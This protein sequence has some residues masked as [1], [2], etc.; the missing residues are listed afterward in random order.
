[1][2]TS[3]R[4]R[5]IAIL[6][7]VAAISVMLSGLSFFLPEPWIDSILEWC[8]VGQM[9]HEALMRYVVRGAGYLQ[10]AGG[11]FIWA[12]A[13]DVVRY[14]PIVITVLALLLIGAPAFYLIDATAGLPRWWC[15]MDFGCCFLA[16]GVPLAFCLWPSSHEPVA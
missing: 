5:W 7:R 1:M 3:T 12:I 2:S 10:V 9:P 6:L 14:R 4:V 15:F 11:V 8:G 13:R 16:G